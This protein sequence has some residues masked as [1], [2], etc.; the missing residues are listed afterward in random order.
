MSAVQDLRNNAIMRKTH[1][2]FLRELLEHCPGLLARPCQ[3][4][5]ILDVFPKGALPELAD[6]AGDDVFD[7]VLNDLTAANFVDQLDVMVKRMVR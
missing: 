6:T 2:C 5:G 1:F 3:R 7:G 4:F